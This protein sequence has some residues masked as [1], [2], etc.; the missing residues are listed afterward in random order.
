MVYVMME[1]GFEET[2]LIVPVD[3]LRRGGVDVCIVGVS[4]MTAESTRKVKIAADA[5]MKDLDFADM[6]MLLLPGGQPGVDYLGANSAVMELISQSAGHM[7][8]AAIC[9][10]PMLLGKLGLLRGR[11]ATCY[12]GCEDA[13]EGARIEDKGV[14]VDGSFITARGAG[15]AFR[16]GFTLL[17]TLRGAEVADQVARAIQYRG[18]R[19]G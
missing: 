8:I 1:N 3:I 16:F 17:A 2:E 11:R 5:L 4:G 12:P 13:L 18:H 19:H 15:A 9:A 10:A 6:E 7:P 14:V